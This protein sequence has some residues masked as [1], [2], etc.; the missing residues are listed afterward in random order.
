MSPA[1]ER[2]QRQRLDRIA[3]LALTDRESLVKVARAYPAL[4][5]MSEESVV[6]RILRIKALL[7][8]ARTHLHVAHVLP[9][10]CH[11]QLASPACIVPVGS[12][13][14][15]HQ[16]AFAAC[17]SQPMHVTRCTSSRHTPA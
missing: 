13:D 5:A 11:W 2:Q 14:R 9:C 3:A 15:V 12:H 1:E 10:R 4:L 7:P 6:A 16:R 8:G 17:A